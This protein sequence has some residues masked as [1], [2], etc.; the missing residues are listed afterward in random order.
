MSMFDAWIEGLNLPP[1]KPREDDAD[2]AA[3]VRALADQMDADIAAGIPP[4]WALNGA[5]AERQE[6]EENN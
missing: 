5:I 1:S 3:P 6:R 2:L 4:L